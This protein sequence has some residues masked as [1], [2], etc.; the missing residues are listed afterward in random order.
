V[1]PEQPTVARPGVPVCPV[2][3]SALHLL[4]AT[5]ARKSFREEARPVWRKRPRA[6]ECAD[7]IRNLADLY[8]LRS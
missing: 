8:M 2:S 6:L 5:A 7:T 1:L 4:C 3:D